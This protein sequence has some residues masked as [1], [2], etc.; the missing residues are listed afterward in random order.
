MLSILRKCSSCSIPWLLLVVI[1]FLTC[2]QSECNQIEAVNCI[3]PFLHQLLSS[4]FSSSQDSQDSQTPLDSPAFF[5]LSFRK[6][7][8]HLLG[9]GI[10]Q[11]ARVARAAQRDE[12]PG[13]VGHALWPKLAGHLRPMPGV[14]NG[15]NGILI[16]A[17]YYIHIYI[18]YIYIYTY[19]IY[20]YIQNT[21]TLYVIYNMWYIIIY[22]NITYVYIYIYIIV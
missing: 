19:I 22:H 17:Y 2:T 3:L 9:Q 13:A 8:L 11:L 5:L 15:V 20:I 4:Y 12:A 21:D 1:P 14:E 10:P 18:Y 16:M 6:D 7:M